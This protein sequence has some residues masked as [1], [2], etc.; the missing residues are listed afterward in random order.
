MEKTTTEMFWFIPSEVEPVND[1]KFDLYI[2]RSNNYD[3]NI[4]HVFLNEDKYNGV[5]LLSKHALI[6]ENEF[7]YRFLVERKEWPIIASRPR[8][9]YYNMFY[10]DTYEEY[11]EAVEK[12]TTEMFWMTSKNL[13]V[14]E[15]FNFNLFFDEFNDYDKN[16]NHSFIHRCNGEDSYNGILLLSKNALLSKKEVEYRYPVERKEWPIVASGPIKYDRFATIQ[17]YDIV[18]ISYNEPNADLNWKRLQERFPYARRIAGVKG[19]HN[20][21]IQ[22][23]KLATTPM[24]W[25]VDADAIVE[26]SFM[27]DYQTEETN[28]VHVWRSRNPINGL[29]YGYGGVKLLPTNLT[30]NMDTSNPDMTTSITDKFKVVDQVSNITAF[31]TD[32][33]TT[34]RSAFR[35]CVKLASNIIDRQVTDETIHRLDIWCTVGVDKLYGK[36]AILGANAGRKYGEENAGNIPALSN[37]NDFDW[38]FNYYQQTLQ[39]LEKSC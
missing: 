33:F 27:F 14:A 37:I 15:D 20:A 23:S 11:L 21:H 6:T 2:D 7:N 17:L 34:W 31:N 1:F 10:I 9:R 38:L 12:T 29:E 5:M 8:P 4:N 18:F 19:I 28:T 16:I 22:A 26:E 3:R 35:E 32:S 24:F 39:T 36:Y 13:K 30:L 25:V